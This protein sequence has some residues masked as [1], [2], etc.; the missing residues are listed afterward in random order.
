MANERENQLLDERHEQLMDGL[1]AIADRLDIVNG[2]TRRL[3]TAVAV[4][5]WAYG[6]AGVAITWLMSQFITK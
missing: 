2:R 4:L 3:E 5:R 1:K 6:A